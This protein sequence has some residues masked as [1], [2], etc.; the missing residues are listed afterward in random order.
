MV[1]S[2]GFRASFPGSG[3]RLNLPQYGVETRITA[4]SQ[5]SFVRRFETTLFSQTA[6]GENE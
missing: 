3:T 4:I 5:N 2:V 1:P 6:A